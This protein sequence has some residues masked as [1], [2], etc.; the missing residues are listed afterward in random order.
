MEGKP[1][2][3]YLQ[4]FLQYYQEDIRL[5]FP[6]APLEKPKEQGI[7]T[8]YLVCSDA[9]PVGL[10]LGTRREKGT[11]EIFV[12]YSTPEYRDCSVGAYLYG[13]L[14]AHGIDRLVMSLPTEKHA[15]YLKSMGFTEKDRVYTKD[16]G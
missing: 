2:D 8:A 12:D 14:P 4:Y 5:Y 9:V 16:F 3:A 6:Q 10:L 7:D 1:G 13:Q 15:A 11:L